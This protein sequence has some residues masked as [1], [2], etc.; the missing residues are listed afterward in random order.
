LQRPNASL[1]REKRHAKRE[2]GGESVSR[3]RSLRK[4]S[5]RQES[6]TDRK[7]LSYSSKNHEYSGG[8]GTGD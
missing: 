8:V 4:P 2:V 6:H 7:I 1:S 3:R 5:S